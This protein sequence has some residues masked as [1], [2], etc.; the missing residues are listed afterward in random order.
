MGHSEYD[1]NALKNEYF[2]DLEKGLPIEIPKHYFKDN[3]PKKEPVALWKAHSSLL[4]TNW[5][6]IVYQETPFDINEIH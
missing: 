4:Y 6:N 3:D 5:L 1:N 2:R